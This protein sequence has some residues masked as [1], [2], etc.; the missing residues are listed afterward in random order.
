VSRGRTQPGTIRNLSASVPYAL[1]GASSGP[2]LSP[3]METCQPKYL[4]ESFL[5]SVLK[6]VTQMTFGPGPTTGLVTNEAI[7]LP[8]S[9]LSVVQLQNAVD[10][11]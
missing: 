2:Q 8:L 1:I 5:A 4:C 9:D 6:P 3:I 11:V 10:L 7:P